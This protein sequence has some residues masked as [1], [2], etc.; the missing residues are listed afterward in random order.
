ML[1]KKDLNN[2]YIYYIVYCKLYD[3][4]VVS[5]NSKLETVSYVHVFRNQ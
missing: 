1:T 3:Y 4:L 2:K 5:G